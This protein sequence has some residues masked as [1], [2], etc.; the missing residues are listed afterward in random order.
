MMA[1]LIIFS[2]LSYSALAGACKDSIGEKEWE[3]KN[4]RDKSSAN[5]NQTDFSLHSIV[6]QSGTFGFCDLVG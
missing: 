5:D 3:S 6:D 4:R 1:L 2:F